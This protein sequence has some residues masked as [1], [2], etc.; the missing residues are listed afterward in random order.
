VT[1]GKPQEPAALV[2]LGPVQAP[3]LGP[4]RVRAYVPRR[5][6]PFGQRRALLLFDG[7]NVFGDEGSFAGGWYAHRAVERLSPL[8]HPVPVLVAIDNGGEQRVDELT[9]WPMGARGG[10]AQPFI[11]Q[12]A[13]ELGPRVRGELGVVDGPVGLAVGGS[14]LGGLAALYA[15]FLRPDTFGGAL[16]FSPAFFWAGG[17]ILAWLG[18]QA[19]PS[20]SRVYLDCGVKE[21]GGRMLPSTQQVHAQLL[22]RG[23]LPGQLRFRPDPR[24]THHERHWRRR[25]PAALR[26]LYAR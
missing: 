16:C 1:Y 9:G 2:D 20:F 12:L 24:G 7:Q 21:S 25:L 6:P 5:A 14:S 10:K 18:G 11:D 3:G 13:D 8:R 26:F 22:A 23:Y 15:H 17:A 4:R 19:V